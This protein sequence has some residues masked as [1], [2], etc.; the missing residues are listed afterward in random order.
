[1]E[2]Q[3]Q[4]T[5]DKF[6]RIFLYCF[7]WGCAGLFET[8]DREKFHK[9]LETKNAPLPAAQ[10]SK[11]IDKETI[12]DYKFDIEKNTWILWEADAWVPPRRIQFSQ[13]LIPTSDST[14][15]EFII[16]KIQQLP[17]WRSVKR[18]EPGQ[19]N[20]LLVGG[21]GTAKTSTIMMYTNKFDNSRMLL[22]RI[23][24]SSA[25]TPRNF[26]D[27]IEAEVEKKQVKTYTPP[28]NKKMTVFLDDVSMPLINNWGDQETL[29]IARQLV[30]QKGIYF[31]N[32]DD[33]GNLKIIE[34]LLYLGAMNHPGGG[35]NDIP[36]RF[37]RHFFNMNMTSP[38]QR[39]IENIY[40]AILEHLLNPK[41][42]NE[43]IRNMKSFIIDATIAI[44]D[45]TRKRLLPTPTKFHYSFNIR[46]LAR[47]FG[48][49]CRVIQQHQYK[50]IQNCS[51][52]R[53]KI[54]PEQFLIILW[55]HEANRTFVDKLINNQDKKT[56]SDLLDRVTKDKFGDASGLG[57]EDEQLIQD[58]LFADF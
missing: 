14:R 29:E 53:E 22:K 30:E 32:K 58:Y 50:V 38:S 11:S 23:N 31:L 43:N 9:F 5:E 49:I 16:E 18:A 37:K 6:E 56:F 17:V 39:S 36:P 55:R 34:N 8:E 41:K 10:S 3:Q 47:V 15:A 2:A 21:G 35:R 13:L 48:G 27:S 24:F 1:V 33:I 57:F 4:I 28:E 44:W 42:Y 19:Q 46:D 12:F 20:T 25:T 40:G 52:V 45:V 51:N 7:S 54:S 26:Q